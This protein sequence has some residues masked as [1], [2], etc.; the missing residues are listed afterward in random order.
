MKPG[1]EGAGKLD[2]RQ[3]R[4][5]A[6]GL[7]IEVNGEQDVLVH[8]SLAQSVVRPIVKDIAK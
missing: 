1:A 2:R 3:Q 5:A 4:L 6:G 8:V 7:I